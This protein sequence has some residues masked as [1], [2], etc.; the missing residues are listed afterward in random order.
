[1]TYEE[2]VR[3][4]PP[5]RYRHFK[6]G[7]YE[8]LGIVRNSE[9]EES[10]VLYRALYGER[11]LWVRPAEMWLETVERDGRTVR[12]F[13]KEAADRFVVFDVETPNRLN[14][15]I[16]AIGITVVEDGEIVDENCY[17]VDPETWFDS[18]NIR[19]TGIDEDA[20]RG[21]MNFPQLWEQIE[22]VMNSGILV[23]HNAPFDLS[24]LRR[25][26]SDYG[27]FWKDKADYLCT[28]QMS[29]RMHPGMKHN[30]NV[31]CDYYG[32]ELDHHNAGSDAN[33]CARILLR[34]IGEGA[35][36]SQFLQKYDL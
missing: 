28:V 23:A 18:F 16:S 5:G 19:L 1:M 2:A 17:L 33:A 34:M 9:T 15:R 24:V 10:M 32:I 30:L 26:L 12:R 29:R 6:G 21:E 7:A 4:I 35:Q 20:V 25:C 27:I 22:P 31:M 3:A 11:Q 8:V 13:E 36:T 14:D